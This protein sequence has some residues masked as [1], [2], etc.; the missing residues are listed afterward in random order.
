MPLCDEWSSR[1]EIYSYDAAFTFPSCTNICVYK[2]D[3]GQ[4]IIIA[5]ESV[6]FGWKKNGQQSR[7]F[8]I[9]IQW[10]IQFWR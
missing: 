2:Y 4:D 6:S 10:N 9:I 1:K 8:I 3:Y 5:E 7:F